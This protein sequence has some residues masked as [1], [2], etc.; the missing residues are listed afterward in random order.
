VDIPDLRIVGLR[1]PQ[2]IGNENQWLF[3]G[4]HALAEE[5]E[6]ALRGNTDQVKESEYNLALFNDETEYQRLWGLAVHGPDGDH[7][8]VIGSVSAGV[9]RT[10]DRLVAF[11]LS[12]ALP[13]RRQG[14]GTSLLR[15][16]YDQPLVQGRTFFANYQGDF[17]AADDCGEQVRAATGVG[18]APV[19]TPG[20]QFALRNGYT[21]E[22]VERVSVLS[23]PVQPALLRRLEAQS[24]EKAAGYTVLTWHNAIPREY[25]A[26][27]AACMTS[28][29]ADAPMGEMA[30]Q[31]D[32]WDAPRVERHFAKL[33]ASAQQTLTT[34]A[35]EDATG[36]M[37]AMTFI[38]WATR[39][40]SGHQQDTVVVARH[41]GHRLG[42]LIK[43]RNLMALAD[44]APTI[45]R[46]YTWNA[47]ENSFM[48][49]INVALGFVPAGGICAVQK[50][51]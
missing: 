1:P 43:A 17:S 50:L 23:L 28:V 46:V 26:G 38:R 48:L 49:N 13:Y 36:E 16:L 29:D 19:A 25:L 18:S 5:L 41:R 7:R 15:W 51:L 27:L 32:P 9:D 6:F 14:V 45:E 39:K 3:D 11:S 37:A 22:Q 35:I 30:Y 8:S 34:V 4:S 31:P 21:F 20:L 44:I 2:T 10:D 47:E 12:V 40:H 24:A 42:M 33:L